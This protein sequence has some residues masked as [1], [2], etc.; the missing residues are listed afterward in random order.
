MPITDEHVC[1][2]TVEPG[3]HITAG[4]LI[5]TGF[6]LALIRHEGRPYE[7]VLE[8]SLANLAVVNHQLRLAGGGSGVEILRALIALEHAAGCLRRQYEEAE[9]H[10]DH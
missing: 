4:P 9:R 1:V 6:Q 8:H 3:H 5:P 10:R 7:L 2:V